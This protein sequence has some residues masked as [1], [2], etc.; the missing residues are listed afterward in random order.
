[1]EARTVRVTFSSHKEE[2]DCSTPETS[3]EELTAMHGTKHC[4]DSFMVVK[5]RSKQSKSWN[6]SCRPRGIILHVFLPEDAHQNVRN[7][8]K[9]FLLV[10]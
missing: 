3:Q 10:V 9:I 4:I 8:L 2:Y 6:V 1:M 5:D 7:M